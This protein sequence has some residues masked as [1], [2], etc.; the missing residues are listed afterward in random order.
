MCDL[1]LFKSHNAGGRQ[2]LGRARPLVG[3]TLQSLRSSTD[4]PSWRPRMSLTSAPLTCDLFTF[5]PVPF[6]GSL[7]LFLI[8][9][10]NVFGPGW[11]WLLRRQ[12]LV[13]LGL[14]APHQED[15]GYR[16]HARAGGGQDVPREQL[17]RDVFLASTG[18]GFQ[19]SVGSWD[20]QPYYLKRASKCSL[21]VECTQTALEVCGI[22]HVELLSPPMASCLNI[23]PLRYYCCDA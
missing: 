16:E 15:Q 22:F 14:H 10:R 5:V 21:N 6:R 20:S 4:R 2:A 12:K 3:S 9:S 19:V 7:L 18:R 11:L 17:R 8:V 23:L 13:D 1:K